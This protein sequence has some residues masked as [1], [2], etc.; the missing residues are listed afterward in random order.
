MMGR[1]IVT[2]CLL[3]L[4]ACFVNDF[5][6]VVET[7]DASEPYLISSNPYSYVCDARLVANTPTSNIACMQPEEPFT[8]GTLTCPNGTAISC[9]I[10]ASYGYVS[11]SCYECQTGQS[12]GTCTDCPWR[13]HCGYSAGPGFNNCVDCFG[14][15]CDGV[16][17]SVPGC[18]VYFP[19]S[20]AQKCIG[21]NSCFMGYGGMGYD[22]YWFNA[23]DSERISFHSTMG[24]NCRNRDVMGKFKVLALC[25]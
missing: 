18:A 9:F 4:A 2:L 5:N 17:Y 23:D 14:E 16:D 3:R 25:E 19:E 6:K 24:D 21:S 22:K 20:F 1:V 11:G 7:Q 8:D 13:D 10:Y 15:V 12:C